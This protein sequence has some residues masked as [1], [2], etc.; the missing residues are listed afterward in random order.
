ML[1]ITL[2]VLALCLSACCNLPPK[3]SAWPADVSF[4]VVDELP[5]ISIID[6]AGKNIIPFSGEHVVL[7]PIMEN[8]EWQGE[9]HKFALADPIIIKPGTEDIRK[10]L[11]HLEVNNQYVRQC[12]VIAHGYCPGS[13]NPAFNYSGYY[14]GKK[15]WLVELSKLSNEQFTAAAKI[16]MNEL[17][18]NSIFLSKITKTY[19]IWTFNDAV[20]NGQL[21]RRSVIKSLVVRENG[22]QY[23]II[24][25]NVPE[26]REVPLC[27][28]AKGRKILKDELQPNMP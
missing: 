26:G 13:L 3:G 6:R 22:E 20:K 1:R 9:R 12:I 7:L 17:G 10:T 23:E 5:D 27:F 18:G 25:W 15:G 8:Y 16:M 2:A 11:S 24:L 19:E 21:L 4:L 28:S 14:N